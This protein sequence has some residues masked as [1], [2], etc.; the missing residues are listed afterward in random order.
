MLRITTCR[1]ILLPRAHSL[2]PTQVAM[3]TRSLH[4]WTREDAVAP[5]SSSTSGSAAKLQFPIRKKRVPTITSTIRIRNDSNPRAPRRYYSKKDD[6]DDDGLPR[7]PKPPPPGSLA[8]IA[9]GIAILCGVIWL[10]F[11]S[12][13]QRNEVDW[14]TVKHRMLPQG[15]GLIEKIE[16]DPDMQRAVLYLTSGETR[17]LF[18]G[19]LDS[20]QE[21][22]NQAQA[23]L[24]L[25]IWDRIPITYHDRSYTKLVMEIIPISLLLLLLVLFVGASSKALSGK[26]AG[27]MFPFG[28]SKIKEYK[29]DMHP[30]V[31]FASVAGLDEAKVEVM[32]FVH[33]LK[34]PKKYQELGATIP[35]GC[36][37]AGPPGTGKTM[38]A[39]A[40]AG[41]AGVPFFSISGSDFV[42]MFVGVGPAR[43]RNLFDKARQKAPCIVFIDEIDAVGRRR[44][45]SFASH[46]ER[47]NTLNQ[48]LVE[49]DGFNTKS[50]VIVLAGTNMPKV[51]DPALTRPGRFDRMITIDPPD[52]KGRRDILKVH[53]KPLKLEDPD[54]D[55]YAE[56]IAILTP[57]MVG[58][59]LRNICNEG[60]LVAARKGKS[61]V[62][63]EDLE[64]A[65]ERVI[66][67]LEKQDKVLSPKDRNTVAFHE[68]GHAVV[69]WFLEHANP[70][71]KVS[72]IPRGSAALGYAQYQPQELHLYTEAQLFDQMCVLLGGRIAEELTFG[73]IST[74]A[75]DD[76]SKVTQLAYDQI[77]RLGMNEKIGHLSFQPPQGDL[78]EQP[79]YSEA[80]QRIIDEEAR[81]MV[82]KA[83]KCTRELLQKQAAGLKAVAERLLAKEKI[84]KED[85]V[86]LLGERP[87]K[88]LRTFQELSFDA[89]T[90]QTTQ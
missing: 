73:S 88:E 46:D 75:S 67:G 38:M 54:I 31:T 22:I 7:M 43:V 24:G 12:K 78:P 68:A 83:Q 11:E 18:I 66:G 81:I 77:T 1:G 10:L 39:K 64:Y 40:V 30:K 36:L 28:K 50:G 82:N 6:D 8:K 58:A 26:G 53:L 3:R 90:I 70:L 62:Q 20:F 80:T 21:K 32:E 27:G 37:L 56:R 60:A 23:E 52:L 65:I 9:A 35:R 76:L 19:D 59:D 63:M 89:E 45:K 79:I 4:T 42:E 57:G 55:K 25:D 41:E 5:S 51:L 85:M 69:G 15:R 48:L 2:R 14:L 33:F 72:I 71:L 44:D 49:M 17:F 74:G 87:W 84:G 13:E 61:A 86:E 47:D 34:H 16:L 29:A